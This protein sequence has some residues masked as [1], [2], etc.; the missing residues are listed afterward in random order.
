MSWWWIPVGVMASYLVAVVASFGWH[1]VKYRYQ[2]KFID[3]LTGGEDDN[4]KSVEE[5]GGP[6]Q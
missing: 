4:G 1:G 3:G 5:Q 2:K 6:L